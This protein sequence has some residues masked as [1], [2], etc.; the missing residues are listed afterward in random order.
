MIYYSAEQGGVS[1]FAVVARTQF[2]PAA[3]TG[4]LRTALHVVR[5]SLPI[6]RLV[7]FDAQLGEARAGPRAT[8]AVFGGFS[9]IALLLATLGVHAVV[10]F[11]V[12]RRSRE[13]GIPWHSA[14]LAPASFEWSSPK[15]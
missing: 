12:E 4:E 5:S 9:I 15:P 1:S 6:S 2:D 13:L 8:T 3:L 7:P 14:P 10:A 11:S